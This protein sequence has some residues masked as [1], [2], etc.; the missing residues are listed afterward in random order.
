MVQINVNLIEGEN[1]LKISATN[2]AGF[3]VEQM[4]INYQVPI[5]E[6]IPNY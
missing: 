2:Q 5:V 4:T 1:S 6:Q 3:D